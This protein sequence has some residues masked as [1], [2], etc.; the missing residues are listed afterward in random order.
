MSNYPVDIV[1][2]PRRKRTVSASMREGRVKVMLPQGLTSEEEARLIDDLV[3]RVMR[4]ATSREIDLE[5]RAAELANSYDL[6][7]P[8]DV[9]WSPRQKRI[10]GSCSPQQGRVR[11][12]ERLAMVPGWVL[13]SVLIHELAHIAVPNHGPAFQELISRYELAERATGYLMAL[14]EHPPIDNAANTAAVPHPGVE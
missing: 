8:V 5:K 6:P 11:I 9:T 13:D 7:T 12:S 3:D 4:K 1:R 10:W 14:G 2:S